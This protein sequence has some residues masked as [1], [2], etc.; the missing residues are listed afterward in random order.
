MG[1]VSES[2]GLRVFDI[3][4]DIRL[5][6]QRSIVVLKLFEIKIERFSR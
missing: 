3:G 6:F 1:A 4:F 5:L 2:E